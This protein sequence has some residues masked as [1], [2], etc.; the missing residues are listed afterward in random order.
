MIWST[1]VVWS[2]RGP[3]NVQLLGS[4]SA[5]DY[6][7]MLRDLQCHTQSV[8]LGAYKST[9]NFAEGALGVGCGWIV[10]LGFELQFHSM[11]SMSMFAELSSLPL[12]Y[13]FSYS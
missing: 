13:Y 10:V 1:G 11:Q 7:I 9:S 4:C 12:I 2:M 8:V 5:W 3:R 6:L